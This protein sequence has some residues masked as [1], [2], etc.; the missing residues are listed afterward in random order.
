MI[1]KRII[2]CLDIRDGRVVKGVNFLNVRDAGDPV[3]LARYYA[4]Q[5]ADEL[6]FL[7]ITASDETRGLLLKLIRDVAKE[8]NIPFTV[9]GGIDSVKRVGELLESGADKASI[10]SAAI[11]NPNLITDIA[12]QFGSQCVTVAIDASVVNGQWVVY[13]HGGKKATSNELYSWAK[14]CENAG[15]GEILFTSI[16]HDGTKNGF[17]IDALRRLN[18]H[19]NIAVIASG[20]AGSEKHFLEAFDIGKA[21][22]VLAASV[23]HFNEITIPKL[24]HYLKDHG[25]KIRL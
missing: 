4:D 25:L 15:A 8:I 9:G 24:K 22:A 11:R 3:N 12:S 21:D 10:N 6:T 23:F 5:G 19:L 17:A 7:D 18:E 14:R 20:G 1:T 16:D 13:S 2:P